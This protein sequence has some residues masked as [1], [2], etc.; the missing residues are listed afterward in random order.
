VHALASSMF[1]SFMC[2]VMQTVMYI[3]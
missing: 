3:T 1:R 2:D